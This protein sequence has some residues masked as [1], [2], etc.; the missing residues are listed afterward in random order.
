MIL[1][2]I[3]FAPRWNEANLDGYADVMDIRDKFFGITGQEEI[4]LKKE[5]Y[6]LVSIQWDLLYLCLV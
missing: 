1:L 6:L 2:D 4:Q 3:L 5:L